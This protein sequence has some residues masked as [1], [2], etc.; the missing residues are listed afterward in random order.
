MLWFPTLFQYLNHNFLHL[1]DEDFIGI[2]ILPNMTLNSVNDHENYG[3]PFNV[4][5]PYQEWK[6]FSVESVF[7]AVERVTQSRKIFDI[8]L[9]FRLMITTISI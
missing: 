3:E 2:E 6:Q 7:S 4:F 5:V 1:K 8:D 9:P